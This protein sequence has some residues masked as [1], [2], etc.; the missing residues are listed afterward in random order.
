PA[1]E[2]AA[3]GDDDFPRIDALRKV[4]LH[5]EGHLRELEKRV[6][7]PLDLHAVR[8]KRG[9]FAHV[10]KLRRGVM[11][12]LATLPIAFNPEVSNWFTAST[13]DCFC[14]GAMFGS[15]RMVAICVIASL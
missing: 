10:A 1:H 2:A 15:R 14:S 8:R 3:L 11:S 12:T 13:A 6:L 5:L 9:E 4:M 7:K